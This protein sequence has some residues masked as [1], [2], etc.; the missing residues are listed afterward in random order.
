MKNSSQGILKLSD[1]LDLG[2]S[3]SI[4]YFSS[5]L[6]D[7]AYSPAKFIINDGEALINADRI[8]DAPSALQVG[9]DALTN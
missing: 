9:R 2:L 7:I 1:F 4:I 8:G 3:L 5:F 6:C